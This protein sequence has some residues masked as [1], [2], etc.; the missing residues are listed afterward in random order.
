MKEIGVEEIQ[1]GIEAA[2]PQFGKLKALYLA[3]AHFFTLIFFSHV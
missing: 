2:E 3:F 1:T